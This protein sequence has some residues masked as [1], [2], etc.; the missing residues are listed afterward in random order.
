MKVLVIGLVLAG[1]F[2]V[3]QSF[4]SVNAFKTE[5]QKFRL[6]LKEDR[7]EIRFYPSAT[8]ATIYSNA[9][10]YRGLANNGFRKLASYIFG[11]NEQKQSISMTAPV[12]MSMSEK[13]S[14][15]SF[16]MPEKFNNASLPTPNDKSIDIQQSK[17]VYVALISFSGYAT[18]AKIKIHKEELEQILKDKGIK[19]VGAYSFLGYNAPYQFIGRTNEIIIPIEWK[20]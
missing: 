6:V 3:F 14:S 4:I 15:M 10:D 16:V 1:I 11:G 7:F 8:M 20:E 12:I 9:T 13:G 18:D 5:K 2:I 19:M 17:P